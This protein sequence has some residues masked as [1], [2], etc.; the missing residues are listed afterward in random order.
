MG[1]LCPKIHVKPSKD[2]K[3]KLNENDDEGA[4]TPNI[5]DLEANHMTIGF[6]KYQDIAQKRKLAEYLLSN[7]INIYKRLLEEM[8]N[9][10]DDEF[11]ELFEG[12][13]EYDYSVSK[14]AEFKQLAQK[15]E[16]NKELLLEYYD[17]EEYY[18]FVLQIWKSNVLQKLK[19]AE[20]DNERNSLLAG[21]GIDITKWDDKFKKDLQIIMNIK[22]IKSLAERMKNYIEADYGDFD[23]LI[24]SVE[25]C[26]KKVNKGEKNH[27]N[28]ILNINLDT[29]MKRILNDFVPKF[30]KQICN[31][32]ENL[33][34]CFRG[35][36]E[37]NAIQ[38]IIN[39][40]ISDQ[41]QKDL[42][43]EVKKIYIRNENNIEKIEQEKKEEEKK[44]EEEKEKEQEQEK[45][46]ENGDKMEKQKEKKQKDILSSLFEYNGEYKKLEELGNKFNKSNDTNT[47]I[48]FDQLGFKDK[49]E[50]IF[51]NKMI[52][53]AI[54]GLSLANVSYSILHLTKTFINYNQ[55][56]QEFRERL[57]EI[58]TKFQIHKNNV[59]VIDDKMD[60][61]AAVEQTIQCGK[62][63]QSDLLEVEELINDIK[64]AINGIKTEKTNSILNLVSSGGSLLLGI[65]GMASTQGT[66]R[67]EYATAS[68]GDFI[69]IIANGVDLHKQNKSI[70]EFMKYMDEA[71]KLRNQI[72]D[73]INKLRT[74]F[75]ELSFQH[76]S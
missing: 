56:S 57:D 50:V 37:E 30:L 42:I 66:D 58:K 72:N 55:Y 60:I 21:C 35:R 10:N 74:K 48:R 65:F 1:C 68:L 7:D 44:E 6:S 17:K 25:H 14:K 8:K 5:E 11:Y 18:N 59:R 36:E 28:R 9:L 19:T 4:P 40:G 63:F 70:E 49:A 20:D 73:E 26:K 23:E 52:K 24:K 15:F 51:K 46:N 3:E 27:C 22:P 45:G 69:A 71:N 32:G 54:L 64:N 38:K 43:D 12:N 75:R 34:S 13:T 62:D 47:N 41:Q 33:F 76:F 31:E 39:S 61:D 16:N 2:L 29:S 67:I 53:H